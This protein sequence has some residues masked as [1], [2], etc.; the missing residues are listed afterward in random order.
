MFWV[1]VAFHCLS[2]LFHACGCGRDTEPRAAYHL[3]HM[4]HKTQAADSEI[5]NRYIVQ[6]SVFT[7]RDNKNTIS[8]D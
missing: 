2:L 4:D 8:F 6:I 7:K 1:F 5:S 3:Q